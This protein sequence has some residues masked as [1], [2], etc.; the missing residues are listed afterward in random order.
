MADS[1]VS[2]LKLQPIIRYR[3][4][5]Q[6]GDERVKIHDIWRSQDMILSVRDL[7]LNEELMA[8]FTGNE[9]CT[10]GYIFATQFDP[11]MQITEPSC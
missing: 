10:I 2:T 9:A 7:A 4:L 3:L 1:R 6:F 5:E 8:Q 11:M